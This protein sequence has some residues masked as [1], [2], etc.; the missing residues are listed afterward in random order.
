MDNPSAQSLVAQGDAAR[1]GGDFE[2]ALTHYDQAIALALAHA[3]AHIGRACALI[4]LKRYPEAIA[5]CGRLLALTP[6]DAYVHNLL[7]FALMSLDYFADAVANYDHA[8]ALDSASADVWSDRAV[9]L[10]HQHRLG[11]ALT[12][13]ERARALKPDS[14]DIQWNMALLQLMRGDFETGWAGYESRW[15]TPYFAPIRRDF[16]APLWL[17][18]VPLAG[19]TILIHVEQGL[20]DFIL[21]VRYIAML[22]ALGARVIIETAASLVALTKTSYPHCTVIARGEAL[23]PHDTHC[24]VMSLPHAFRTT[25]TSVPHR[26]PYLA[27]DAEKTARWQARLGPKTRPRIGIVWC[28]SPTHGNDHR[29]S[30][31]LATLAPLLALPFEFHAL[32][33]EFRAGERAAFIAHPLCH[34]H[35]GTLA[36]FADTAALAMAMDH[37]ISVDTSVAHLAGALGL[38]L[39]LLLPH[40]PD[41]RWMLE[42]LD[43]PWYPTARLY[44]QPKTGDWPSALAHVIEGLEHL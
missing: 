16:I 3:P 4:E 18:D 31:P 8:L 28:G 12:S 32:T 10:V 14:A 5:S 1:D 39:S 36:D 42:R 20:G 17:G 37:I 6:S 35:D 40:T 15:H 29:R 9:A 24:P 30:I 34:A 44:R 38:P 41:Y 11:E 25:L 33:P 19:K 23:P 22:E 13:Y 7:G 43:S 26:V 2:T 27:A 21:C